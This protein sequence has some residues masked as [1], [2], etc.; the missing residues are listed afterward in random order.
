MTNLLGFRRNFE[1][2]IKLFTKKKR[3]CAKICK[4]QFGEVL[5]GSFLALPQSHL[6]PQ[7]LLF[8]VCSRL[9]MQPH[10]TSSNNSL[11][12][13]AVTVHLSSCSV[14][15]GGSGISVLHFVAAFSSVL[16][17]I[18]WV[19]VSR[20]FSTWDSKGAKECKSCRSRKMLKHAHTLAIGGVDTSERTIE[21]S[22][23]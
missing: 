15:L 5:F 11:L 16:V 14:C 7:S 19:V 20:F 8:V 13:W 4:I 6:L 18:F 9:R 21:S 23:R 2:I 1:K 17:G 3:N 12:Q 10:R 22:E